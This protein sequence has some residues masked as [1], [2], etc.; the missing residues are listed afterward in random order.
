MEI[1]FECDLIIGWVWQRCTGGKRDI[2]GM[3]AYFAAAEWCE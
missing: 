2:E 3:T 1:Q